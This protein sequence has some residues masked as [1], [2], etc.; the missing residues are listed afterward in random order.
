MKSV[1][2]DPAYAEVRA[3]LT[4]R[5]EELK[6]QYANPIRTEAEEKQYMSTHKPGS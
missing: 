2:N 1:Y 6:Q 5:L 3:Q 4:K